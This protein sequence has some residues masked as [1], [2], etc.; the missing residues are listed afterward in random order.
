MEGKRGYLDL[1]ALAV[2]SILQLPVPILPILGME[3]SPAPECLC[4]QEEGEEG[5]REG[6]GRGGGP[7][8]LSI[9]LAPPTLPPLPPFLPSLPYPPGRPTPL[10]ARC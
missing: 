4:V 8:G 10:P 1:H 2:R 5:G 7:G 3:R 6:G 9:F